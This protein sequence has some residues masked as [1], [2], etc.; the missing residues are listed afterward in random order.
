MNKTIFNDSRWGVRNTKLAIL[1][2]TRDMIHSHFSYSLTQLYATT[3]EMG[4]D[5]YLFYDSSTIL[6][7]QREKLIHKAFEVNADYVIWLDSDMMFPSTTAM[8]LLNHNLDIVA[9]NYNK[10]TTDRK[11]VAYRNVGDW[12]SYVRMDEQEPLVKVEGTGMGCMLMKTD[13]F[14]KLSKPYF[15]FTYREEGD[16]WH[17]ED[18]QLQK[19]LIEVGCDIM[20]DT[21]LSREIKHIGLYAF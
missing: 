20:I 9:C 11:T 18:F 14:N 4:I 12:D 6:L 17:G 1:V 2:P 13:V 8:R 3:R 19:K 16:F 21:N 5:A 10:R 15:E 7:N